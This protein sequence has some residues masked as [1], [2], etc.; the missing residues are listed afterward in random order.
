MKRD[1][2]SE[3]EEDEE[4]MLKRYCWLNP[5]LKKMVRLTVNSRYLVEG[6]RKE[7]VMKKFNT[8]AV[9]IPSK[10]YMVDLSDRVAEIKKKVDAGEYFTINYILQHSSN[11]MSMLISNHLSLQI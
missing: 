6:D 10:H 2:L 8:T 3:P 7:G 9:C 11:T 1:T 5:D 4:M